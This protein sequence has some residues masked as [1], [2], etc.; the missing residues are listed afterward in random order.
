MELFKVNA[1]LY[2]ANCN[3]NVRYIV[4]Q[5]GTGSGKTYCIMQRLVA[6][7]MERAGIIITVAGQD[8]PNLKV[9]AIRDTLHIIGSNSYLSGWFEHNKSDNTFTGS[10]GS[11]IEFKSYA[12]EQDAKSGKR[13]YLF[14]NEANGMQ[15]SVFWQLQIRTR[16]QVFIDYNPSARFWVHDNIINSNDC[17]LVISDHR[18]NQFLPEDM[19]REIENIEDPE[20]WKVYARGLTGKLTGLVFPNFNIVD[21]GQYPTD[22]VT[23]VRVFGLDFGFSQDYC[24]LEEV[25]LAH[26]QLWI[27]ERIYSRGYTN[28]DIAEECKRQGITRRDLIVADQAEPKSIQEL[29]NAGLWV[30]P[31]IKGNDSITYGIDLMRRYTINV[32]RRSS[33]IINEFKQY[34]W[35][36]DR[37]GNPTNKPIDRYNHGVD[38]CRYAVTYKLG[39]NQRQHAGV[40]RAQLFRLDRYGY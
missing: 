16:N 26:G 13:D 2:Q 34:K 32:T 8:L 39:Y 3:P 29:K 37:D 15:F 21:T 28:A 17:A 22:Q 4:N 38:S 12:D 1:G 31:C 9:G 30:V 27:N 5:G 33:G 23:K 25:R 18:G 19:H 11:L 24:A 6:L 36:L 7:S 20:L 35:A 10:N 40:V 14:V